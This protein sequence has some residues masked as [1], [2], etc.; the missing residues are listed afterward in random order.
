MARRAALASV[1]EASTPIRSPLTRPCPARRPSTQVNTAPCT[2]S[3]SRERV[4]LGH[5]WPGTR[6]V[7][8][9]RSKARWP[10]L[11]EG[12]YDG[13]FA[14][15]R[16]RE[17]STRHGMRHRVVARDPQ[18]EG[19]VVLARRWVAERSFGWLSH[20]GGLARNRAGRLDVS[21]ARLALVGILSGF[22]ALL[23]PMP[24]RAPAR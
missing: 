17:W 2:S 3:G 9:R 4:L 12:I 8:R 10:P 5:E 18:A 1:V 15:E 7:V 23:N 14:T 13:A 16:C 19:F 22:E 6:S 24:I 21:A 20:W 11:R